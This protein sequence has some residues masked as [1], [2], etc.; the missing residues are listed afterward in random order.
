[1]KATLDHEY[2]EKARKRTKQKKR[3]YFHFVLFLVGSAFFVILNK[4]IKFH[5]EIDWYV[6]AIFAW[7]VLLILHFIN[8]FV[9]N[10]FFDK[11]WERLQTEKLIQK[12][13]DKV[14]KLEVKLEKSGAFDNLEDNS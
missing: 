1:M 3:L 12:H 4:V 6:W 8:V 14:E 10:K 11:D 7:L 13:K 2:Y 5:P 9:M